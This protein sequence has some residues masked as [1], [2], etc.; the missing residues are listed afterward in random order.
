MCE[1]GG[2][3][4]TKLERKIMLGIKRENYKFENSKK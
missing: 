1:K 2:E 4:K 3:V